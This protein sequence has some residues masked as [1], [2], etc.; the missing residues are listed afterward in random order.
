ML[1]NGASQN[2]C[3][4][5]GFT[6][7]FSF[8]LKNPLVAQNPPNVQ[9]GAVFASGT[10]PMTAVTAPSDPMKQVGNYSARMLCNE[11]PCFVRG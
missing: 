11:A 4:K 1:A 9:I 3:M 10:M 2:T 5:A 7:G 8:R 6:Y